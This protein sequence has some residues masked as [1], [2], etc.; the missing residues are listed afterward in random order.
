MPYS[1]AVDTCDTFL[2]VLAVAFS[3][4]RLAGPTPVESAFEGLG[5]LRVDRRVVDHR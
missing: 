2:F 4:A 5:K 1:G 3:C